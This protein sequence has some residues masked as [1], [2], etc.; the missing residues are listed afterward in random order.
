MALQLLKVFL[1]GQETP[2]ETGHVCVTQQ[3]LS[4]HLSHAP[5]SQKQKRKKER[6]CSLKSKTK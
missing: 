2:E 3:Q 1:G 4:R 6:K 5:K